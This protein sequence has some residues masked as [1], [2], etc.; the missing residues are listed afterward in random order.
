MRDKDFVP[1]TTY[2][3]PLKEQ[4]CPDLHN[5]CAMA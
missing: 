1:E 4:G 3:S 5:N 2:L